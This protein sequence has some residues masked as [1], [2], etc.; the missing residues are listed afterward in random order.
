MKV[1]LGIDNEG[2][3]GPALGMPESLGFS[4]EYRR[5]DRLEAKSDG[6]SNEHCEQAE[7]TSMRVGGR[8]RHLDWRAL[9]L[10]R[11]QPKGAAEGEESASCA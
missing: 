2:S 6:E 1:V 9:G 3:S 8:Y 4:M 5:N 7:S 10:T 11:S